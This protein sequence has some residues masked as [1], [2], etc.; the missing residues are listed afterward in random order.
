[1]KSAVLVGILLLVL[2]VLAFLVLI[3]QRETHRARI[4]GASIGIQTEHS[5]KLP[6]AVGAVLLVG[7]V[8]TLVLGSRRT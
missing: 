6:P 2:G 4:E 5:E 7:G 1:M 8:L 3:P